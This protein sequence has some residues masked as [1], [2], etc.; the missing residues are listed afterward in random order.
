[1][2]RRLGSPFYDFSGL[3][4]FQNRIQVSNRGGSIF[5]ICDQSDLEAGFHFGTGITRFK[6]KCR[7]GGWEPLFL[8]SRQPVGPH[9]LMALATVFLK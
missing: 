2:M 5:L 6:E 3:Y 8:M 4:P 1:M 7:P 9:T